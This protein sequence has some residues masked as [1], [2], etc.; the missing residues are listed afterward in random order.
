MSHPGVLTDVGVHVL[1]LAASSDEGPR[2]VPNPAP[3]KRPAWSCPY[4]VLP[5]GC[6]PSGA[7]GDED[8]PGQQQDAG[9]WWV[10]RSVQGVSGPGCISRAG[11]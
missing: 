1:R 2:C 3:E 10:G 8:R 11:L 4:K 5:P 9:V 6:F 7:G